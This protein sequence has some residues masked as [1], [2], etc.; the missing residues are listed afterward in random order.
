MY[1]AVLGAGGFADVLIR[2][3]VGTSGLTAE[4]HA[5]IRAIAI[6]GDVFVGAVLDGRNYNIPDLLTAS[7]ADAGAFIDLMAER[8]ELLVFD[9]LIAVR[10]ISF[11]IAVLRAS[12]GN[13]V[14]NDI[15]V[16]AFGITA[17]I[18]AAI[19]AV[20]IFGD[21]LMLTILNGGINFP[22]LLATV[23]AIAI[24]GDI[25]MLTI[26]NGG[27]YLAELCAASVAIV[28]VNDIVAGG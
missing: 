16:I 1:K 13:I 10:A 24:L 12:G 2:S 17:K 9:H 27:I 26:L 19:R 28:S 15:F 20:A 25:L 4:I 22:N 3:F 18:H 21:I 11:H 8:E 5:A 7:N 6:L 14:F 23:I